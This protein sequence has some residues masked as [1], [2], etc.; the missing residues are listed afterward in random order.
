MYRELLGVSFNGM[1]K[2]KSQLRIFPF[3]N[4]I[5]NKYGAKILAKSDGTGH[6][7]SFVVSFPRGRNESV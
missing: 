6:G 1:K 3:S 5:V 4:G 2:V 7:S